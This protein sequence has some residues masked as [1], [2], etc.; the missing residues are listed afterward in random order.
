MN[1]IAGLKMRKFLNKIK[2]FFKKTLKI[3]IH[4][5]K[6]IISTN[7]AGKSICATLFCIKCNRTIIK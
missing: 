1:L 3:C 5:W 2:Y 4:D 6:K 7:R